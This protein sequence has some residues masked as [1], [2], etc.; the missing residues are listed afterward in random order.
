MRMRIT[1][2][3]LLALFFLTASCVMVAKPVS[4]SAEIVENSWASK[5]PMHVARSNLGVAVVNGKIYAIGGLVENGVVTGTNEEYDPA[6]DT[7]TFRKPM[8]TARAHFATAVYQNKIY[9][10]GGADGANEVYDPAKD[11][12]ENKTAMPTPRSYISANVVNGKI[13]V[14]GGFVPD[15]SGTGSGSRLAINEVYNPETDSWTTKTPMPT[16]GLSYISAVVDNKI[17][18]TDSNMKN[19]IYDVETDTWRLG[20]SPPSDIGHGAAGAITGVNALKRIYVLTEMLAGESR[21]NQVYDPEHDGWTFGAAVPTSRLDF[22][23]A[24]VDDS[25]YAIGGFTLTYSSIVSGPSTTFYAT[26]EQ[27]TPFGYGTVPPVVQVVS[28]ENMTYAADNVSLAFT[29]NKPAVWMGY[30]LDGQETV[31]VTGNTTVAGLSNGLHNVTVYAKDT[32]ENMG[33]SETIYFSVEVPFPTTLVI[34]PVAGVVVIGAVLA[35]YFKK[36]KH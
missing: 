29:V 11:T 23:V 30:S 8:P 33:T 27:Y 32:F 14:I 26:N 17:Y 21:F 15:G 4:S 13:Y 1:I 25:L 34:A 12:W 6:T 31:T 7:W 35:I 22:N 19:Q 16:A 20:A 10:I 28:P 5:A 3:L 9:C 2:V 18:I 24:V 36:R